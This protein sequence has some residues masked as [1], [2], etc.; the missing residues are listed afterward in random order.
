[1]AIEQCA[2]DLLQAMESLYRNDFYGYQCNADEA[3]DIDAARAKLEEA[4]AQ[5]A[6]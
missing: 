2:R 5:G 4:L 6:K 1:M 3:I